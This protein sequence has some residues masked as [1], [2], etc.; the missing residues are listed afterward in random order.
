VHQVEPLHV[1]IRKRAFDRPFVTDIDDE[2]Q[3]L[4]AGAL[5]R[6]GGGLDGAGEFRVRR[7]RFRR[8]GDAAP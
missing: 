7:G 1:G 3:R 2:R 5:D 4:A 8:N 6:F